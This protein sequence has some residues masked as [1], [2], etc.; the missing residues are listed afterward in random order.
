MAAALAL[1]SPQEY[2]RWLSTYA[3]H[4]AGTFLSTLDLVSAAMQWSYSMCM[5]KQGFAVESLA[6]LQ[7]SDHRARQ[8]Q[9]KQGCHAVRCALHDLTHEWHAWKICKLFSSLS[10]QLDCCTGE[11]D[12]VRLR[13]LCIELLGNGQHSSSDQAM[14]T[15]WSPTVCGLN[16]RSCYET[17]F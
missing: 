7:G 16:K 5:L 13:E 17:R 9:L 1:Q 12:G 3:S 11:G 10:K 6:G 2:K 4:L 15:G 14:D 8:D